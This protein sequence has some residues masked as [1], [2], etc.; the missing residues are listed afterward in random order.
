MDGNSTGTAVH[1]HNSHDESSITCGRAA[2]PQLGSR[3]VDAPAKRT[4]GAYI[5]ALLS[6]MVRA[7]DE[8]RGWLLLHVLSHQLHHLGNGN[9]L[10]QRHTPNE[11]FEGHDGNN[12]VRRTSTAPSLRANP[13]P[14]PAVHMIRLDGV[15]T[16]SCAEKFQAPQTGAYLR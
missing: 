3:A 10:R 2:H 8:E 6:Y 4:R 7:D 14:C 1:Y 16:H 12:T 15:A 13:E 9:V 5:C 11:V